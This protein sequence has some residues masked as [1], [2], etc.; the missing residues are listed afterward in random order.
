MTQFLALSAAALY[1]VADFAGGLATRS[2]S[3]WR[4]TVWSQVFGLP[5]LAVAILIVGFSDV[6]TTDL[7]LGAIAGAFGLVGLVLLYSALAAGSMSVVAPIVG[8]LA[9]TIPVAWDVADGGE[10]SAIQWMGIC[11]AIG[12]V[13]LLASG[14]ADTSITGR[15]LIQAVGAALA[16]SVFV[17]AMSQTSE[18]SGLWPLVPARTVSVVVGFLVLATTSTVALPDGRLLRLVGFI[19]ITEVAAGIA[20]VLAV[21]RGPLGINAVISSLYPAFTVLAAL[22]VLKERPGHAQVAGIV[23]AILAV[24]LLAL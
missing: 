22:I 1:G 9:A 11:V 4:V 20:I 23:L 15:V 21:Q 16:F 19:G 18:A 2:I 10:I 14:R 3:A 24:L 13:L 17:I 7:L 12:A 8:V 6:T 5:L